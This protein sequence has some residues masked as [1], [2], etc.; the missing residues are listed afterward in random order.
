MSK[1]QPTLLITPPL[2]PAE[3]PVEREEFHG[4]PCTCCHGNGWF[5]GMDGRLERI[6]QVC[7]VCKGRKKLKAIV[8]IQW[9]ADDGNNP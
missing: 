7:P 2:F 8:T 9:V 5:W 1:K 4:I 3:T 6:K